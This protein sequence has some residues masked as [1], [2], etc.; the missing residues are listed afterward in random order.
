MKNTHTNFAYDFFSS[1]GF[2]GKTVFLILARAKFF[3]VEPNRIYVIR[4]TAMKIITFL[5]NI[6]ILS[7]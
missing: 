4:D 1:K 2:R 6:I 7:L 3:Y 5:K